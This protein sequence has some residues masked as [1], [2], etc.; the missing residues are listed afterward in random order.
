MHG[1]RVAYKSLS[2]KDSLKKSDSF[3][4]RREE[5]KPE[6]RFRGKKEKLTLT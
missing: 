1:L 3:Y 5:K 2:V 6:K 4:G